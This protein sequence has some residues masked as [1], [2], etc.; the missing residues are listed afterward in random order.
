MRQSFPLV[1]LI[2]TIGTA[3]AQPEPAPLPKDAKKSVDDSQ[4]EIE[5]A[6]KKFQAEA[7]A[8]QAKLL[9]DLQKH[10]DAETKKGNLDGAIAI[11]AEIARLKMPDP[12]IV[13]EHKAVTD[14]KKILV[15]GKWK[16]TVLNALYS[17]T[18]EFKDNLTLTRNEGGGNSEGK[19]TIETRGKTKFLKIVWT[20]GAQEEFPLPLNARRML[21]TKFPSKERLELVKLADK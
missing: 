21:G 19:W 9:V 15:G 16:L 12:E 13:G 7:K 17:A 11:R 1:L 2:L 8:I 18:W 4:A 6:R 20:E 3:A 5:K 10:M 14:A